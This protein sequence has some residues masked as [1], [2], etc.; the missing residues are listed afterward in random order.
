MLCYTECSKHVFTL[1]KE[2]VSPE[3]ASFVFH[4]EG[5]LSELLTPM[6]KF[7]TPM[8]ELLTAI[9]EFGAPMPEVLTPM[10][11]FLTAMP[12]LFAPASRLLSP[13]SELLPPTPKQKAP[14]PEVETS[15][16]ELG[17]AQVKFYT[18]DVVFLALRLGKRV[19]RSSY[20]FL[21]PVSPELSAFLSAL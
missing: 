4:L 5:F 21:R 11:R 14:K 7:L 6:S 9:L 20:T 2:A 1:P 15:I 13:V 16:S 3:A 10:S 19:D 8:P 18:S 12:E 17:T